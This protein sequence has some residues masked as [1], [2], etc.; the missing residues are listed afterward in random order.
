MVPSATRPRTR[1]LNFCCYFTYFV[2]VTFATLQRIGRFF[3]ICCKLQYKINVFDLRWSLIHL[4]YRSGIFRMIFWWYL[5]DIL[6]KYD[7]KWPKV[8]F[9]QNGHVSK[10]QKCLFVRNK[11][12]CGS[13]LTK[14]PFE[15]LPPQNK[16]IF[17]V[18]SKSDFFP[19]S[20]NL[21]EIYISKSLFYRKPKWSVWSIWTY[22]T[23]WIFKFVTQKVSYRRK[24]K[25]EDFEKL[26]ISVSGSK[27]DFW[28]CFQDQNDF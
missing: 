12:P 9:L 3:Q 6:T 13:N 10:F 17:T 19:K 28:G 7:K 8:Q 25:I 14:G 5:G 23:G 24:L 21:M 4:G 26:K 22:S 27:M 18:I 1:S 20:G 2:H 15:N 11:S 16:F